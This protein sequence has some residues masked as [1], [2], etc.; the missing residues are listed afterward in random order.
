M[1]GQPD[2]GVRIGSYLKRLF[3]FYRCHWVRQADPD[4]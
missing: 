4:A 1:G 2:P 3:P